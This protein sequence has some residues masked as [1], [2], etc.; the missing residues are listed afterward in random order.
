MNKIS[1]IGTGY[2]GLVTGAGMAEFG[3]EVI[4]ADI[5]KV[6]NFNNNVL[7]S[8]AFFGD[9]SSSEFLEF[10]GINRINSE[11]IFVAMT[12]SDSV[13]LISCEIAKLKYNVDYVVS[14]V[15]S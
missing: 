13:N 8:I 15:N 12:E 11:T 14:V 6:K 10:V 7:N 1:I 5:D 2:V 9:S 4:C 3:N